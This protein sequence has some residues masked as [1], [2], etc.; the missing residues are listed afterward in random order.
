[1]PSSMK[2]QK[3]IFAILLLIFTSLANAAIHQQNKSL[4]FKPDDIVIAIIDTG[5]DVKHEY[6]KK[7]IWENPGETGFDKNG[8]NKSTN[9]IDDDQNG[10]IDDYNG[11]N[12]I[13]NNSQLN[14]HHGHGTHIA[15]IIA[16]QVKSSLSN[17]KNTKLMI[18]KYYDPRFPKA[19]TLDGTIQAINYAIQMK[20]NII[21]FSGGGPDKS[22]LERAALERA[23]ESGIL[24]I[25]AAGNE[26][27]NSDLNG[28]Y[29]ADYDLDN[30]LS[31]TATNDKQE[32]LP[33]SN[34]GRKSVHFAA[35]GKNIFSTLPGG[36]YGKM[37]GTSQATAIVSGLAAL[38]MSQN[39]QKTNYKI[40]I[41]ELRGMS[42]FPAQ[43]TGKTK[44]NAYLNGTE[45]NAQLSVDN[46]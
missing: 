43:I 21:N 31:I 46:M 26:S 2:T 38:C 12:F 37:S 9:G 3:N 4:D 28:F 15:G 39:P 11:W 25:A 16:T 27:R 20:V 23:K 13:Q 22:F 19:D 6:F 36:K 10:F 14:D 30:I 8:N 33:T 41:D 7:M 32:I 40:I 17:H 44:Y 18:L 45:I 35:K 42:T 24:V 34:Y 5:A 29:P 1:M